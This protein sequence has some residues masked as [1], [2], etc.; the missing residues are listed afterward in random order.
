MPYHISERGLRMRIRITARRAG[1]TLIE[2]LVVIAIIAVLIA[3]LLPAVQA[4][5]EAARRAQCTNNLKQIGLALMN[6]ESSNGCFPFIQ[7]Q[8]MP[9]FPNLTSPNEWS[10]WSA[11]ALMLG[12][13]EQKP[14]YDSLNFSWGVHSYGG[15]WGGEDA[16][17]GTGIRNTINSFVCPSDN[18][19]GRM[20][21]R[22]S[23]GTNWDWWSRAGGAGPLTRTSPG[24]TMVGTIAGV[25][26]GTSNTIAFFERHRGSGDQSKVN[27]GTVYTG[28]PGTTWGMPS[29]VLSNIADT[30]YLNN[31]EIPACGQFGKTAGPG[32]IWPW[33]GY[34]WA[35]GEYTNSVG[36]FALTPNHKT[37]DCSAWGGVGTGIGFFS[38]RSRHPGGVNVGMTDGS[39]RFV[40]D[41]VNQRTWFSLATRDGGEVISADAF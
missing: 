2:L 41:T 18:G 21:Y 30:N 31:T 11:F 39:V 34:Y 35:A 22:A 20:S 15:Q 25:G 1:F 7:T 27:P 33:S 40:K 38:A 23:N 5:R 24:G 3:L 6:Y 28:G 16:V 17:Q 12:Y 8:P 32:A 9:I 13:M 10:T 14:I 19:V 4:A 36:N 26:D 37:V 29:Y